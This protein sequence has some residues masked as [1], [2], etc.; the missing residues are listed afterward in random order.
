MAGAIVLGNTP[1][2]LQVVLNTGVVWMPVMHAKNKAGQDVPW[3]AET[4]ARLVL[5]D[6]DSGFTVTWTPVVAGP[7]ITFNA[8]A[9]QT[10]A[11]PDGARAKLFLKQGA[12]V[13]EI[14]WLS[15]SVTRKD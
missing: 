15:G 6:P 1:Q 3:P 7:L 12:S 4:T 10:D 5:S 11:V 2:T 13:S 14:L 8:T 9:V